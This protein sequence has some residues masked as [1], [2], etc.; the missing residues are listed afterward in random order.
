M[1]NAL[2]LKRNYNQTPKQNVKRLN[3]AKKNRAFLPFNIL[4]FCRL[5]IA[6]IY[7]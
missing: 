7:E 1:A 2:F 5:I 3:E 4:Y 6:S